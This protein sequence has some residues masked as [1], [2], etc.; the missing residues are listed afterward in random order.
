M[1]V[2]CVARKGFAP[3]ERLL[4]KAPFKTDD[5]GNEWMWVE[6]VTWKGDLVNGILQNDP[7]EVTGLSAGAR[8]EF[9]ASDAF[10]YIHYHPDGREEGNTTGAILRRRESK[11]APDETTK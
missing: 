9:R 8:V 4:L 5:G 11:P 1:R 2:C 10:D 6:V 7:Y 3:G